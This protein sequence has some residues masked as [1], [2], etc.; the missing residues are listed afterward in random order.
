M[1]VA[2]VYRL[3]KSK[4][5][6]CGDSGLDGSRPQI[7]FEKSKKKTIENRGQEM[8]ATSEEDRGGGAAVDKASTGSQM[9]SSSNT[10]T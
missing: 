8:A 7:L 10:A 9:T 5:S 3:M 6:V 4:N 1:S 2:A